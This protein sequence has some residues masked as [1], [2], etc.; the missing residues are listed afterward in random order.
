MDTPLATN[1]FFKQF[2]FKLKPGSIVVFLVAAFVAWAMN[3]MGQVAFPSLNCVPY[4][5][6][7][8]VTL[9]MD[10]LLLLLS[11][12]LLEQNHIGFAHLGEVIGDAASENAST[13]DHDSSVRRGHAGNLG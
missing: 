11:F 1:V 12:R 10:V 9:S 3:V 6:R 2:G 4:L 5:I 13:D 7:T 8:T